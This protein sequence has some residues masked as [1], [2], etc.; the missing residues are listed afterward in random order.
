MKDLFL[1]STGSIWITNWTLFLLALS[2]QPKHICLN[3]QEKPVG[4]LNLR[5]CHA[6]DGEEM[7]HLPVHEAGPWMCP[8]NT[9]LE[10]IC[11]PQKGVMPG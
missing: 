3:L 7:A 8:Q 9:L 4:V 2:Q 6:I 5:P 11:F 1:I 10:A